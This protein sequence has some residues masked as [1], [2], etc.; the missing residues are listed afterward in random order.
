V[1]AVM[2]CLVGLAP[3][4]LAA[5]TSGD[6]G[7][8]FQAP[9][10]AGTEVFLTL[11]SGN[12]DISGT[13]ASNIVVTCGTTDDRAANDIRMRF[14]A[15]HLTVWGGDHHGV[16]FQ[17]LV[18]R[19]VHLRVK[20]T[21]GDVTITGITGNKDVELN[22]GDLTIRVGDANVY[23]SV[24]ASVL[25]GDIFAP[26]FNETHSGLFRRFRLENP[27]GRYRLHASLL[28]GNLT[29]R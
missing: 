12:V 19:S 15:N 24:E 10:A 8:P 14:A 26:A 29:L 7:R 18:P 6:C 3:A 28:A 17:I 2:I 20:C 23:R 4:L 27:R 16:N 11:R 1:K 13:D 9:V 22:A 5:Q 21:A 25:A